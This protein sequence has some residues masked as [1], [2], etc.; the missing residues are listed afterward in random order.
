M[1]GSGHDVIGAIAHIFTWKKRV[2]R[3]EVLPDIS[4]DVALWRCLSGYRYCDG[5][6]YLS[7]LKHVKK[8]PQINNQALIRI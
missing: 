8:K 1:E 4:E 3:Y 2:A 7:R 6:L 5:S